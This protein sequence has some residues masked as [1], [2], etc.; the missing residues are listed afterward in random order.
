MDERLSRTALVLGEAA[1]ERLGR[2]RV[3]VFGLGGVGG[4]AAE[5]LCRS[6]VGALD[7]IDDDRIGASNLNR[8]V[9]ALH[10]T[11]GQRK[12]GA[13][14]ARF[15]D[16][17][18]ECVIRVHDVF[19]LPESADQ[20]DFAAY[21]YVV[22]AIDTV[23]GK[24]EL[25]LRCRAAG[26]P[27]IS[28]MGTGNKLDPSALRVADLADTRVCP[29]AR[30]MR[31]ELRRRGVE[32]LKV[33]Y[34]TEPPAVLHGAAEAVGPHDKGRRSIPGSTVF[35]PAAAGLL[36]AAEVVRELAGVNEKGAS[37]T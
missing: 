10:S 25:V 12:T 30:I 21:D 6:G 28:A 29:L 13:A 33:V 35:V 22:D 3:A 4:W 18:P 14:A 23:T 19:F 15:S 20:F 1:M 31:K 11:L 5:A 2:C 7:L 9:L 16:I 34:S 36:I 27:I 24:L 32:H 8:Q 26:T 17:A 37:R